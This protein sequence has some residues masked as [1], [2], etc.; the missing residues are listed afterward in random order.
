MK[1]AARLIAIAS[2]LPTSTA[3]SSQMLIDA[4][5]SITVVS[6]SLPAP[7][8]SGSANAI[9]PTSAPPTAPRTYVFVSFSASIWISFTM[10]TNTIMITLD[11]TPSA[12]PTRRC[13]LAKSS[14]GT[15]KLLRKVVPTTPKNTANATVAAISCGRID[16]M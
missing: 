15:A 14:T 13:Q 4:D 8:V 6:W 11:T 7:M 10:M 3:T 5:S 12:R 9:R 2:I 16:S 1:P